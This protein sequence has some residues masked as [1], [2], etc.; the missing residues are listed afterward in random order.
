[1]RS[2]L[3]LVW[4]LLS[5]AVSAD[6]HRQCEGLTD[7]QVERGEV[8][9]AVDSDSRCEVVVRVWPE[10]SRS[11]NSFIDVTVWMPGSSS[12]NQR[13]LG[14]GN[15][16]YCP[17]LP[18]EV[19]QARVAE[20]F[21]VAAS[22]TGHKT[23]QLNFMLAAPER[24]DYWGRTAVHVM[25]R[26]AKMLINTYYQQASE[27]NYF[28][29][30]STGGHQALASAQYYP[31]DFDG[32]VA[33][34]PGHN[35]VALNAAFLW[36][37]QQSHQANTGKPVLD[38]DDLAQ[39]HH[40]LLAAC[41]EMDGQNDGIIE[42][43]A[44]CKPDYSSFICANPEQ[45]NCLSEDKVSRIKRIHEGPV[46]PVTGR[47]IYPGFPIGSE[48]TSGVGWSAYW[49]DPVDNSQPARADF[50]RYWVFEQEDWDPWQFNWHSDW[51][52]ATR[53][54]SPRI[55][56]TQTDLTSF[57]EQGSKLLLFHGMADPIVSYTD[58]AVYFNQLIADSAWP[59][60][61]TSTP[62]LLYLIPG[63]SHC[64]GGEGTNYFDPF[65]ALQHWVETDTPP[66]D[67][68]AVRFENGKVLYKK[69]IHP[70]NN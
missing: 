10:Q 27:Y 21:A 24:M 16:G 4:A 68:D 6:D 11:D 43:P 63:M 31:H 42:N 70:V 26:Y 60:K 19:M 54:L 28:A 32:I 36:L 67:I 3:I 61:S 7:L 13:F 15:G 9:S 14:V 29:G 37:Y 18:V 12:W 41:D 47:Q 56:A 45:T 30:C 64:G 25:A 50:W 20:G 44:V 8:L 53:K 40:L 34:A 49:A 38:R 52:F 17:R 59:E 48:F 58:S 51:Q 2:L 65:P 39:Y 22:D 46:D 69:P 1:M 55:D 66:Q 23:E 5:H 57:F 35:R 62:A 33:G